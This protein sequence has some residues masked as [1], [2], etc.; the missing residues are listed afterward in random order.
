M[1]LVILRNNLLSIIFIIFFVA[2]LIV[3]IYLS[4]KKYMRMD[5]V[6]LAPENIYRQPRIIFLGSNSQEDS[7]MQMNE[8][9]KIP[10]VPKEV[11]PYVFY[12]SDCDITSLGYDVFCPVCS[13]RMKR[14][15]LATPKDPENISCIICHSK[16]CPVCNKNITGDDNCYEECPYCEHS[17]H[18]HCW[19]K[20]MQVFGKCGHCLERPPSQLVE[21]EIKPEALIT[22]DKPQI[23]Y[24]SYYT[25]EDYRTQEGAVPLFQED[26]YTE[27]RWDYDNYRE[28]RSINLKKSL[29]EK[30][31]ELKKR[32]QVSF[33]QLKMKIMISSEKVKAYIEKKR[34]KRIET[35]QESH[36]IPSKN[37]EIE[38]KVKY[39]TKLE[40]LNLTQ[41]DEEPTM[42]DIELLSTE[43]YLEGLPTI[44]IEE[45]DREIYLKGLP[46]IDIEELNK[47]IS[48]EKQYE[49]ETGK[50]AIWHGKTT[51]GYLKW[52]EKKFTSK[53]KN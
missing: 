47:E 29:A 52:K 7:F 14:P 34:V 44:D 28:S 17:Y 37:R 11:E 5:Q 36:P 46:K 30:L 50:H 4:Y 33:Q 39:Q 6:G 43:I 27:Y 35:K 31:K 23:E 49:I 32:F 42:I 21:G 53:E 9:K 24:E 26:Y 41:D 25:Q 38:D 12:C 18:K 48:L 22:S 15:E 8:E 2:M 45:L 20:T 1:S 40:E 16:I 13:K 19:E 10:L 51:K 3:I